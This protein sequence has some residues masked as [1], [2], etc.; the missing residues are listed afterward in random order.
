LS[1]PQPATSEVLVLGAGIQGVCA[2]LAL[3]YSGHR[4]IVIDAA[5]DCMQ[6]ASMRNEGKVHL[7]FVY[8]ND[9]S[10]RTPELMLDASLAF[11]DLLERWIG[12]SL[13]WNRLRSRPFTYLVLDD[14]MLPPHA[15]FDAYARLQQV[16]EDRRP[17]RYVGT[18]LESLYAEVD[19]AELGDSLAHT[20]IAAAA[21]TAEVAVDPALLRREL[22]EALHAHPCITTRFGYAV[23]EATRSSG[24]FTVSGTR[25]DGHTWSTCGPVVVNCLWDHRIALDAQLGIQPSHPWVY[26]LKYRVTGELPVG[27]AHQSSLTMVL[28]RYG[29]LVAHPGRPAYLSWYPACIAGWDT[30]VSPPQ[31]WHR[32]C[33]GDDRRPQALAIARATVAA[34][35]EIVPALADFRIGTVDAGVIV[36]RGSTDID[37]P[38]SELHA[39]A[40]IGVHSHDGWF[41]IDT[42]KLTT[43][44]RFAQQLA[45]MLGSSG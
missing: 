9:P 18:T 12:R 45:T 13:P 35:A 26:R 34:M 10:A 7:G 33:I 25:S 15:I 24:G 39:R 21:R 38:E 16:Y 8:A 37:D 30:S 29:D 22:R 42:G 3:A 20:R 5:D 28:G 19:V 23:H 44:P 32:A 4:V 2:A 14:S 1:H 27:L 17:A 36:A 43:A 31:A 6:R 11:G 40:D 41:S